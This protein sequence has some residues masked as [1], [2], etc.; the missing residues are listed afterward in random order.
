MQ[1]SSCA[2]NY[3]IKL[4]EKMS[5]ELELKCRS[6]RGAGGAGKHERDIIQAAGRDFDVGSR[7]QAR[8][9]MHWRWHWQ[10]RCLRRSSPRPRIPELTGVIIENTIKV[11]RCRWQE[12]C[13]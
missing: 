6:R 10:H 3:F 2:V 7:A 9:E 13:R 4:F 12:R 11:F 8:S 5:A 1:Q